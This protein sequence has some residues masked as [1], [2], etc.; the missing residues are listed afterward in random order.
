MADTLGRTGGGAAGAAGGCLPWRLPGLGTTC[1]LLAWW[2]LFVTVQPGGI[3]TSDTSG[4]LQVAR[5]LWTSEPE[6]VPVTGL[7]LP[8]RGGV[9]R[10]GTGLGQS[11]LLLPADVLSA[12]VLGRQRGVHDP[13][14]N[15][16]VAYLVFPLL[17]TISV[18]LMA[19][20][21]RSLGASAREARLSA[22]L[23]VV[24]SS[25]L[26]HTAI[27]QENALIFALEAG[28]LLCALRLRR[29]AGVGVGALAGAL[30]G[31]AVL[32]RLPAVVDGLVWFGLALVLSASAG[33]SV[34]ESLRLRR[35]A[36]AAWGAG[37][38]GGVVLDRL[39]QFH[40]FG[41]VGSTYLH[42]WSR[43]ARAADPSL[44]PAFPFDVPLAR[45]AFQQ[46][47]SP[48][49]GVWQS[50]LLMTCFFILL[51]VAWAR[52]GRETRG[53]AVACL[54]V[55]CCQ[56]G[57]YGRFYN[58]FGGDGW[59]NRFLA[60]PAQL[61]SLLAAMWVVRGEVPLGRVRR[62]LVLGTCVLGC[63]T[64]L[65]ATA[66]WYELETQQIYYLGFGFSQVLLRFANIAASLGSGIGEAGLI[67]P[68]VTPRMLTPNFVPFL[69]SRRMPEI[70][71][72]A[73]PAWLL[74]VAVG[75]AILFWSLR[76]EPGVPADGEPRSKSNP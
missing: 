47:F 22:S 1:F 62:G 71:A 42:V 53:V 45:G 3:G 32:T 39:Y 11:L 50:E 63:V 14:R 69:A 8:G 16:F 35:S 65:A 55:F 44:P 36:L 57:F 24:G 2:L 7:G 40:R 13:I 41:E 56:V 73:V 54:L 27:H 60:T 5:A 38:L 28:M 6:V 67:V 75:L 34:R 37:L 43:V 74:V 19:G 4:R 64:G 49:F 66:F 48:S 59:G 76:R 33:P 52:T 61:L 9:L 31:W 23:T 46:L 21:A 10:A 12:A 25:F 58:W 17:G 15:A 72:W 26:A 70:G 18:G 68:G 29:Q 20:L 51:P 30:S